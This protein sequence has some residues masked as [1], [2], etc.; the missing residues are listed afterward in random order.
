MISLPASP[1]PGDEHLIELRLQSSKALALAKHWAQAIHFCMPSTH[2]HNTLL[3][4]KKYNTW[5]PGCGRSSARGMFRARL[6]AVLSSASLWKMAKTLDVVQYTRTPEGMVR[7]M[8]RLII[9]I[10]RIVC[11]MLNRLL[12]A[13]GGMPV[14]NSTNV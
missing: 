11:C 7:E 12:A 14:P 10:A 8:G 2:S 13:E 1:L 3:P 5:L 6:K 4:V 9:P